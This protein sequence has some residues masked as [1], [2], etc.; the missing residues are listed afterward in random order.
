MLQAVFPELFTEANG[1]NAHDIFQQFIRY[2]YIE[3]LG[4]Q[5][6]TIHELLR[7]I[8]AIEIR[9]QQPDEWRTYHK[10]ALEY[11]TRVSP[12]SPDRY[13]HAIAFDEEQG[14]SDWWDAVETA[15][16]R[17]E[18]EEC[19][20]LLQAAYDVTLNLA[21]QGLAER[22]FH[23]GKYY[24][25]W[26]DMQTAIKSYETALTL[27]RQI[28]DCLGEAN[29]QRAIGDVQESRAE[30]EAALKSYEAALLLSRQMGSKLGEANALQVIGDVQY[31][32]D[33]NEAALASYDEAL[34]LYRQVEDCLGEA[35]ALQAMGDVQY[36]QDENEAAM[37]SYTAALGLFR[38][39]GD[40]LGE[41]N[42]YRGLA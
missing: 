19:N 35:N 14:M 2:P 30:Y 20:A 4:N 10:R 17:S 21:P 9:E 29:V 32:R 13:Y 8:Q 27:Y 41:A 39:V 11:L 42:C 22:A 16:I 37:E 18:R 12:Q 28:E 31:I 33:E 26:T 6:R 1:A 25:R 24:Y 7:E 34:N 36:I 40:R 3:S 23:Q 38:Q 15:R 5:R